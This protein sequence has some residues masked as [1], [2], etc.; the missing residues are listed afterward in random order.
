VTGRAAAGAETPAGCVTGEGT[1]AAVVASQHANQANAHE[2]K[3]QGIQQQ[4]KHIFL[5]M[6]YSRFCTQFRITKLLF[7]KE[8]QISSKRTCVHV[9]D[10]RA[11]M[12]T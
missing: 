9:V 5:Q 3:L 10:V 7:L 11:L 6:W 2:S 8:S 12:K 1:G 4:I